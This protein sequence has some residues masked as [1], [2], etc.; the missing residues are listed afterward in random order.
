LYASTSVNKTHTTFLEG[1]LIFCLQQ[2]FG[3]FFDL[4]YSGGNSHCGYMN[5][6]DKDLKLQMLF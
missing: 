3:G 4:F 5:I 2:D 6:S 1:K